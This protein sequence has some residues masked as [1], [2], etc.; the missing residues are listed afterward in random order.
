M[1]ENV[2][3]TIVGIDFFEENT[4]K[5]LNDLFKNLN[6]PNF[7]QTNSMI[8]GNGIKSLFYK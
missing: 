7:L 5:N 8:I 6:I 4:N 1:P 2:Y 3:F